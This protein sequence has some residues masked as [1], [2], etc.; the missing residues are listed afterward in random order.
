[1]ARDRSKNIPL[2]K[3]E[4]YDKA[5]FKHQ[6][7]RPAFNVGPVQY[8]EIQNR[9][10]WKDV[11]E[12]H[13]LDFYMIFLITEGKGQQTFG[14][15]QYTVSK[16]T[17]GFLGPNVITSWKA[18]TREQR[19]YFLAFS[20]DFYQ[21]DLNNQQ[22]ISSLPFFQ[23]G[24]HGILNLPDGQADFYLSLFTLMEAEYKSPT[25][26]SSSVI[27]GMLHA[28]LNKANAGYVA[29]HQ[30]SSTKVRGTSRLLLAF[31]E[32]YMKDINSI[33]MGIPIRHRKIADYADEL[34]VTANHLNDTIKQLTGYSA[35]QLIKNQLV[36]QASMC[37]VRSDKSISEISYLLGFEDTSYFSRFYRMHTG[38]TPTEY[39]SLTSEK[40][41]TFPSLS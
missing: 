26:Y 41:Q 37:L 6:A 18:G 8:F 17:L 25:L 27:R 3:K 33:K 40:Y 32:L 2:L 11:I 14:T 9:C 22:A 36:K 34:S 1:M 12:A 20:D 38:R 15:E 24:G 19:G 39:R 16:N 13:R 4:S 35:S 30:A 28:L 10:L 21:T 29:Q 23:V 5:Y 7:Q 31:R